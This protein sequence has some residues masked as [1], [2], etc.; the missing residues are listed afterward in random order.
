MRSCH[1]QQAPAGTAEAPPA[2]GVPNMHFALGTQFAKYFVFDD[3]NWSYANFDFADWRERTTAQAQLLNA[4]N[5]DLSKFRARGGK[6]I[7]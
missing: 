5:P 6:L 7:M 3:P 4:T 1:F 2:P